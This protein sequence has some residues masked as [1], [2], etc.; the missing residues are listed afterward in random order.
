M[1]ENPDTLGA[2][3]NWHTSFADIKFII[4]HVSRNVVKR[5][6]LT[7]LS[8]GK[9]DAHVHQ[10]E[11]ISE[12]EHDGDSAMTS[13]GHVM[14]VISDERESTRSAVWT[15]IEKSPSDGRFSNPAYDEDRENTEVDK[16]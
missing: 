2:I 12:T 7:I 6:G 9:E 3:S 8:V 14:S 13:R 11:G 4:I 5:R 15:E 10:Q 16:F 1:I